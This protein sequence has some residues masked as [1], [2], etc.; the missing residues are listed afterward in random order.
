[1]KY[2]KYIYLSLLSFLLMLISQLAF[3]VVYVDTNSSGG[4][5]TSWVKSYKTLESAIAGSPSGQVFWIAKGTYKPVA[6]LFPEAGSSFYG[7]FSGVETTLTQ[8]SISSNPTIFDGQ[9][10]LYHI[11]YLQNDNIIIDGLTITRGKA[12]GS[13]DIDKSGAGIFI[14]TNIH[15][16]ILNSTFTYNAAYYGGAIYGWQSHVVIQSCVFD[17]NSA[18]FGVAPASRGGAIWLYLNSPEITNCIFTNN[19]AGRIGGAVELFDTVN[20]TITESQFISNSITTADAGGGGGLGLQWGGVNPLPS[21]TICNCLFKNNVGGL[22]GG[23][24]YSNTFPVTIREST[25]IGNTAIHGGG[26]MLDYKLNEPSNIIQ[27]R[28]INNSASSTG[29]GVHFFARS[30]NLIS[31]IFTNNYAEVGGGGAR[32]HAGTDSKFDPNCTVSFQN[33]TFYGNDTLGYGGGILA[34]EMTNYSVYNSIMWGNSASG[35]H[36]NSDL[37]ISQESIDI[38]NTGSS[39]L[40]T[41]HSNIESLNWDHGSVSELHTGSFSLNPLFEDPDGID[42]IAGTLDDDVRLSSTSPC[43]DRADGSYASTCDY[44]LFKR[45]DNSSVTN[46]GINTPSY[47]DVGAYERVESVST[48]KC[49]SACPSVDIS[50]DSPSGFLPC[51]MLLL[52]TPP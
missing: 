20:A 14:Y 19:S 12:V 4:D 52:S 11:F 26:L 21:A 48:G 15:A 16:T 42:N 18:T 50:D 32:I 36:Y 17:H 25:F 44:S 51:I 33:N 46:L 30:V 6:T 43:I 13:T 9:N 31:T 24:L 38:S 2:K 7:G 45:E 39:S 40:V 1:M 23:G 8:R 27:S 47:A 49:V 5:G 3:A 37:S 28:F 29:G 34:S 35:T 22:D 41:R 10:N